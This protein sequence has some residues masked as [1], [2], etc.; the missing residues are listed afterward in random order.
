MMETLTESLKDKITVAIDP[1]EKA[2]R[3]E[4]GGEAAQGNTPGRK[5][6]GQKRNKTSDRELDLRQKGKKEL[7]LCPFVFYF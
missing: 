3:R 7:I 2:L 5:G 1:L 6:L 4:T